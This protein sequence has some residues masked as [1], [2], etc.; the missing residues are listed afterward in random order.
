[1]DPSKYK[2]SIKISLCEGKNLA[3]K[4]E[5]GV[6]DPYCV[7]V[8]GDDEVKSKSIKGTINP[9]WDDEFFMGVVDERYYLRILMYDQDEGK[10]EADDDFLGYAEVC[11][12]EL[13]EDKETPMELQLDKAS[14]GSIVIKLQI[15]MQPNNPDED[16]DA[17]EDDE[18][19]MVLPEPKAASALGSMATKP[20]KAA[21]VPPEG[22]QLVIKAVNPAPREKLHL[23]WI[24]GYRGHD[25]RQNAFYNA[26]GKIVWF[27]AAVAVV[28]DPESHT[29]QFFMTQGDVVAHD[30]DIISMAMHPDKVTFATGQSGKDPKICVWDSEDCSLKVT[31]SG[32][33]QRGIAAVAFSGLGGKLASVGLD[34]QNS[35]C[36]WDWQKGRAESGPI[37]SGPQK[38]Y[39]MTYAENDDKNFFS[40]GYGGN[41]LYWAQAPGGKLTSTK[42][43]FGT[44]KG[45]TKQTLPVCAPHRSGYITGTKD[46]SIYTWANAAVVSK[47]QA[48]DGAVCALYSCAEGVVSGGR[49]GS[50]KMFDVSLKELH[51]W[52]LP[53][54]EGVRSVVLSNGKIIAGTYEGSLYQIEPVTSPTPNITPIN[55]GHGG[56]KLANN[57]YS[58]ELWGLTVCPTDAD[59][60]ATCADDKMIRL[61]SISEKKCIASA[62]A[63]ALDKGCRAVAWSPDGETIAAAQFDGKLKIFK[64]AAGQEKLQFVTEIHKRKFPPDNSSKG[65]KGGIDELRFSPDG[66]YL[67]SGAHSEGKGGRGGPIDV[68]TCAT[69]KPKCEMVKHTSFVTHIDWSDDGS[70]MKS[71]DGNPE[72][73]YWNTQNGS[74]IT[75]AAQMKD[76]DWAT[77]STIVGWPVQG[78]FRKL[79]GQVKQMDMT[80]VN[81][82]SIDKDRTLIALGDDYGQVAMYKYP[83]TKATDKGDYYNG[84]S[85]HVPNVKFTSDTEYLISVGGH[86][87]SV[88][89]WKVQK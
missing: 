9:K 28:Y 85:S 20:W 55:I 47:V 19:L 50:V 17:E 86:D 63:G 75:S 81:M 82:V 5:G 46:G 43:T 62:E 24:H 29:Q 87:L 83:C 39:M 64:Y 21:V 77:Y 38:V 10:S 45:Y 40:V 71:T 54:D 30:D 41:V 74:Q 7:F 18:D 3:G 59:K 89:V 34:E 51:S 42:G 31:L 48:H 67:A 56:Q 44:K 79:E 53:N 14:S 69:W 76:V 2:G 36:V 37:K 72:L 23:E 61:Y 33:H 8:L 27:T 60:Y 15:D 68:Y 58:G 80:D 52:T 65:T 26:S 73:L 49:G 22:Q 4:D 32:K 1:M 78:I 6:S 11:L 12:S 35:F 25:T 88:F 66:Q 57:Q 13:E 84:H 70:M 16:D